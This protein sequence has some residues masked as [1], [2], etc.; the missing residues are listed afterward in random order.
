[1]LGALGTIAAQADTHADVVDLFAQMAAALSDDNAPQFMKLFDR[2]M[3]NRGQLE[4]QITALLANAEVASSVELINDEGDE[5]KREVEVD[6]Y[7]ELRSRLRAGPLVQ[8]R[9]VIQCQLEKQDKHWRVRSLQPV[10]FFEPSK[11]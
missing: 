10:E 11:T 2:N 4:T 5:R 9:S 8:R 3:P 6:W 1:M 7:L